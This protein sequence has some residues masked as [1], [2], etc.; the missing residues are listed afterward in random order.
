MTAIKTGKVCGSCM[1]F[2]SLRSADRVKDSL[3]YSASSRPVWTTQ[4]PV[5]KEGR[6]RK[7]E[8]VRERGRWGEREEGK[9]G[10]RERGIRQE[11]GK[12]GNK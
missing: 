2:Q 5:A 1:Q 11:G 12:K 8:G 10:G 4:D 3:S 6:G 9:K 7:R